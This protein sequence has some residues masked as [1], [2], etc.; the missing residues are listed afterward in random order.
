M[1]KNI[2]ALALLSCLFFGI[3]THAQEQAISRSRAALENVQE[4]NNAFL[5]EIGGAYLPVRPDIFEKANLNENVENRVNLAG[6]SLGFGK[7]FEVSSRVVTMTMVKGFYLLSKNKV[8]LTPF[9]RETT[10]YGAQLTQRMG[11]NILSVEIDH[12]Q[13]FP[14]I[15]FGV[16]G[17]WFQDKY[18]PAGEAGINKI[19]E[20]GMVGE[21]GFQFVD[22]G[23]GLFSSLQA[24]FYSTQSAEL[25][26]DY[27]AGTDLSMKEGARVS[28]NLPIMLSL[29]IG[30]RF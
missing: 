15:G 10:Y 26:S 28:S 21:I 22:H 4:S 2:I 18:K 1:K 3:H 6:L 24:S 5:F 20:L 27:A 30:S 11:W 9:E 29:A 17:N 13:L 12:A 7:S 19:S 16:F 23:S 8:T 25:K 14:F